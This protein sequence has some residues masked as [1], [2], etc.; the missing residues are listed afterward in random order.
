M[1]QL[2]CPATKTLHSTRS[3][4]KKIQLPLTCGLKSRPPAARAQAESVTLLCRLVAAPPGERQTPSLQLGGKR[5]EKR[6]GEKVEDDTEG[7][8]KVVLRVRAGGW[9][10]GWVEHLER[11]REERGGWAELCPTGEGRDEGGKRNGKKI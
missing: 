2:R 7:A 3:A 10:S 8:G 11:I 9:V 5:T 4:K 6:E 1:C